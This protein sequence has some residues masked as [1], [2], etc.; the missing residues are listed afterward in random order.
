MNNGDLKTAILYHLKHGQQNAIRKVDL[1]KFCNANE[2]AMRLSL[3]EILD[4]L[5]HGAPICG[6]P[7]PP[8][9]YFIALGTDEID[10]EMLTIKSYGREL[11]RRYSML[12][13]WKRKMQVPLPVI[14]NGQ[15]RLL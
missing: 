12:R 6:S 2:R 11:F 7:N 13:K 5:E 3:R 15:I 1:A 9:G 14:D 8:Y 10:R 4:D